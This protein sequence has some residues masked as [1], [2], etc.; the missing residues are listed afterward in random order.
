MHDLTAH[1]Q[2]GIPVRDV[3]ALKD[4]WL[5]FPALRNVLFADDHLVTAGRKW[6]RSR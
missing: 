2:G 4:Y 5:V 6:T 1:L 3:D